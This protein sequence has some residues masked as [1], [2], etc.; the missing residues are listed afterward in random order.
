[1]GDFN[2][3]AQVFFIKLMTQMDKCSYNNFLLTVDNRMSNLSFL[4]G[5]LS[6][7][8]VETVQKFVF[9]QDTP[10]YLSLAKIYS[11][12]LAWNMEEVGKGAQLLVAKLVNYTAP[13]VKTKATVY[14]FLS[15]LIILD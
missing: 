7:L 11:N 6:K 5:M 4:G 12:L 8:A 10:T 1:M 14:W 2:N 15:T 3:F 9:N 13:N